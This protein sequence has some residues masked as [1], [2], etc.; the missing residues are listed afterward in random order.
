MVSHLQGTSPLVQTKA[1][2]CTRPTRPESPLALVT[3]HN[4]LFRVSSSLTQSS[5]WELRKHTSF[6]RHS[7]LSA[8]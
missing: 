7:T 4:G 6:L 1:V 3:H 8:M 2:R 5:A